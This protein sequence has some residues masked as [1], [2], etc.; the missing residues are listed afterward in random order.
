[1]RRGPVRRTACTLR[2]TPPARR[3]GA[4]CRRARRAP[5]RAAPPPRGAQSARRARSRPAAAEDVGRQTRRRS[6]HCRARHVAREGRRARQRANV[7]P[8][9]QRS[10]D[11][12]AHKPAPRT[13]WRAPPVSKPLGLKSS[14]SSVTQRR[15]TSLLNASF[16]AVAESCGRRRR[17]GSWCEHPAHQARRA[18]GAAGSSARGTALLAARMFAPHEAACRGGRPACPPPSRASSA[19]SA[20]APRTQ[21][22]CRTRTSSPPRRRRRSRRARARG[23]H[24]PRRG[25]RQRPARRAGRRGSGSG[26]EERGGI[27]GL[28]S[29]A[30]QVRL[31]KQRGPR[32]RPP[33]RAVL[34]TRQAAGLPS[35]Q[36]LLGDRLAHM[37]G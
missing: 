14:P 34:R 28:R 21:R 37:R 18:A 9:R 33:L 7:A 19:V 27:A 25:A 36:R 29:G 30:A 23:A 15:S 2:P 17:V 6:E 22:C 13:C 31:Q 24:G 10:Y 11:A 1:M 20:A 4:P 32:W 26:G 12:H 35:R 8:A 16:L 3:G 5:R